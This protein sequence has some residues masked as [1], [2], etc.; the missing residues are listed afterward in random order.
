MKKGYNFVNLFVGNSVKTV[1]TT[2]IEISLTP[3]LFM[4]TVLKI[5][6]C[7]QICYPQSIVV[8]NCDS[9]KLHDLLSPNLVEYIREVR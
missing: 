1:H 6:S 9:I 5:G 2:Y 3:R 8:I 4:W 7:Y